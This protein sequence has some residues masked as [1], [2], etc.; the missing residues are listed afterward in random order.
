MRALT[1]IP[2]RRTKCFLLAAP[3]AV[4]SAIL[5]L[6][7]GEP[8]YGG[9]TVSQWVMQLDTLEQGE[10][11]EAYDALQALGPKAVPTLLHLVQYRDPWLKEQFCSK[12]YGASRS[13]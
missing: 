1:F 3:A 11:D 13:S 2:T 9:K 4:L 5:F 8:R 10:V 12:L 7:P 6:T